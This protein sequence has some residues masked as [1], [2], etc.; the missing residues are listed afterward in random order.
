MMRRRHSCPN[1]AESSV[2]INTGADRMLIFRQRKGARWSRVFNGAL[3]CECPDYLPSILVCL[4]HHGLIAL[5]L[6]CPSPSVCL[7]FF[8]PASSCVSP[9][10][11]LPSFHLPAT[12]L[13]LFLK[14]LLVAACSIK[15]SRQVLFVA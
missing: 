3:E 6:C 2:N 7:S 1:F 4:R 9:T 14:I 12:P 11:Y 10:S 5:I 8:Y 13:F 15:A